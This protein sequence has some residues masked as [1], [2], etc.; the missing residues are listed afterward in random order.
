MKKAISVWLAYLAVFAALFVLLP[1]TGISHWRD[2]RRLASRGVRSAGTITA[3]LPEDHN[4]AR[5]R[6]RVAEASYEGQFRSWPPNPPLGQLTFGQ[7]VVV[8]YD[9]VHPDVSVLGEPGPILRNET[10]GLV[11]GPFFFSTVLA[12]CWFFGTRRRGQQN[13][14]SQ[15]GP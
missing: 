15:K 1:L 13:V 4:S 14:V 2:Y 6:Y 8:Y 11:I 3:I 9:P 7:T 5:Y 10:E 12:L